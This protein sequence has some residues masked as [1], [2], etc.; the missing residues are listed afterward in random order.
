MGGEAFFLA[1]SGTD[2]LFTVVVVGQLRFPATTV[3]GKKNQ[4]ENRKQ[5]ARGKKIKHKGNFFGPLWVLQLPKK[6]SQNALEPE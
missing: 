4:K 3:G 2:S 5:E 6:V 1:T